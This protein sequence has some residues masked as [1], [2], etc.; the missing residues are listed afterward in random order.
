MVDMA[1]VGLVLVGL[2]RLE[3]KLKN[4]R[5]DHEQ[6][7]S[8]IGTILKVG[9]MKSEDAKKI[10]VSVWQA[11]P[12]EVITAFTK[13]ANGSVRTLVKLIGRVHRIMAVNRL[14]IPTLEAVS[15]AGELVMR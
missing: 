3:M 12:Q 5:N 2:P 4:L 10:M 9:R 14:E 6:L 7:L 13:A 15:D 1:E 11:I 8:R